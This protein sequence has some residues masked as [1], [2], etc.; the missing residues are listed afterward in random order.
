MS[1][2]KTPPTAPPSGPKRTLVH[3]G[4]PH[5]LKS[6]TIDPSVGHRSRSAPPPKPMP[7]ADRPIPRDALDDDMGDESF[8]AVHFKDQQPAPKRTGLIRHTPP[9]SAPQPTQ[10]RAV[11]EPVI[12]QDADRRQHQESLNA[13]GR[14]LLARK[15]D[16][17]ASVTAT[18]RETLTG[19]VGVLPPVVSVTRSENKSEIFSEAPLVR[20]KIPSGFVRI[21][22]PSGCI[23]YDFQ[24]LYIKPFGVETLSNVIGATQHGSQTMMLDALAPCLHQD[25]RDLT[26]S[27][28]RFCMY[29]W[30]L[31]SFTRS[32]FTVSWR[33]HYGNQCT[34]L[35]T[36][37]KMKIVTLN[38][39]RAEMQEYHAKGIRMPT[40]RDSEAIS[41]YEK[42]VDKDDRDRSMWL[43]K[44]AQYVHLDYETSPEDYFTERIKVL[45]ERGLPFLE[46]IRDF[47]LKIEH[48]VTEILQEADD[49]FEPVAAAKHLRDTATALTAFQQEAELDART[50]L[51]YSEKIAEL[52]AEAEEI[53]KI[54]AEGGTPQPRKE[55]VVLTFD[56]MSCFPGV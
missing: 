41:G 33:S 19:S 30:R 6:V 16:Q 35:M 15:P 7:A 13:A 42:A 53:E 1:N 20:N 43:L 25:I 23:P 11:V 38:M 55:D 50:I 46:D 9:G 40:V 26:E 29:W 54:L 36:E 44:R 28:L 52:T 56:I 45:N 34:T 14:P 18:I 10:Q 12:Q 21:T 27:D 2:S 3:K 4:L 39:T 22:P 47:A 48:G 31:N 32:P 8:T 37:G 24:E 51:T 5:G 17:N 49:K